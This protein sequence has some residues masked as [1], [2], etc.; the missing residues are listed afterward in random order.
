MVLFKLW[1]FLW[2][3]EM[4]H[5]LWCSGLNPHYGLSNYSWQGKLPAHYTS[6]L[7]GP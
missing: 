7:A 2:G 6:S 5:T 3:W 4:G 1:T